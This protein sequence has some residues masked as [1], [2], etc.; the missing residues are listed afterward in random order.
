MDISDIKALKLSGEVLSLTERLED[1]VQALGRDGCIL[2]KD[3]TNL[4]TIEPAL[5]SNL[6]TSD[7]VTR[8]IFLNEVTFQR[9][10]TAATNEIQEGSRNLAGNWHP[11]VQPTASSSSKRAHST[12]INL[13]GEHHW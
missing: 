2:V 3:A 8:E 5:S 12:T 4:N 11:K 7:T 6:N 13:G 1:I 10:F 9:N